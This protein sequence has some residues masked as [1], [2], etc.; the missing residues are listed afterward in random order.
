MIHSGTT[1]QQSISTSSTKELSA[2]Y[3]EAIQDDNVCIVLE[4]A[5]E[6][7][8]SDPACRCQQALKNQWMFQ[9]KLSETKLKTELR[10][11]ILAKEGNTVKLQ[12][13]IYWIRKNLSDPDLSVQIMKS[14]QL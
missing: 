13:K 11:I 7:T 14:M 1:I 4:V 8:E 9:N 5:P 6:Y 12:D 2:F 10:S 3:N